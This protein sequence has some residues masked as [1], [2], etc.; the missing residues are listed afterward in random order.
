MVH[1]SKG[2]I[3]TAGREAFSTEKKME[4]INRTLPPQ[5]LNGIPWEAPKKVTKEA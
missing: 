2:P 3:L 4:K 5:L 1:R